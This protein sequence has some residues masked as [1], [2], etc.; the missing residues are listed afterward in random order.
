MAST[1]KMKMQ[2]VDR[3][4]TIVPC[5]NDDAISLIEL[6]LAGQVRGS[7]HQVPEQRLMLSDS[8]RLGCDMF[9]R[10]DEQ[11]RG[12]LRIDIRKAYAELVLIN[13]VRWYL[14]R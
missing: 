2:V 9:F 5:I 3:L 7:R 14:S 12:S 6:M 1:Q 8:L 10:D 11:V 4:P 13:T